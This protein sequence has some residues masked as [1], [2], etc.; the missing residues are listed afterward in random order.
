MSRAKLPDSSVSTPNKKDYRIV[1]L[2]VAG[3]LICLNSLWVQRVNKIQPAI[4]NSRLA[5]LSYKSTLPQELRPLYFLP[6]DINQADALLLQTIPG[7][8]PQ[9]SQRIIS[10]RSS[11]N[12][13]KSLDE[14]LDVKGVGPKKNSIIKKHC[15]LIS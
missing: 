9:L 14:L 6:F 1:I 10:L 4:N 13:F 8:G 2:L 15:I 7:I 3:V 5:E 11:R 12:G